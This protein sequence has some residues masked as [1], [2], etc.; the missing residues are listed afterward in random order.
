[1]NMFR[2]ASW[3]V[4]LLVATGGLGSLAVAEEKTVTLKL[5]GKF[6]EFYL[7]DVEKA[8]KDVSGVQSVDL[9][10]KKGHV[11]VTVRDGKVSPNDLAAAVNGV[12]GEGWH[13]KAEVK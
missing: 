3:G 13:C 10:S 5:G 6:C 11:V 2:R 9:K 4:V 7:G 8:L 12:K 1:M